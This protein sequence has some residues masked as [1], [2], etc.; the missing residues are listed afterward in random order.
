MQMDF[1]QALSLATRS[2]LL[3]LLLSACAPRAQ[4][5]AVKYNGNKPV[6]PAVI[7]AFNDMRVKMEKF[8]VVKDNY[9][10]GVIYDKTGNY[11]YKV[12]VSLEKGV[13]QIKF[14]QLRKRNIYSGQWVAVPSS[15]FKY[16]DVA[17]RKKLSESIMGILQNPEQ[18]N[19]VKQQ[20]LENIGFHYMVMKN[21]SKQDVKKWIKQQMQGRVYSVRLANEDTVFLL[22]SSGK[23]D[24]KYI[25]HLHYNS[26][27]NSHDELPFEAEFDLDL[28]TNSEKYKSLKKGDLVTVQARIIDAT[29][30]VYITTFGLSLEEYHG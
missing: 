9:L 21:L 15:I 30:H 4:Y 14:V 1:R 29:V 13:L 28:H 5:T 25:A 7:G 8:N 12:V 10:S 26:K 23:T 3:L 22:N 16:D 17:F 27:S 20:L 19:S 18:Y 6:Y 11:K 2:L 24:K